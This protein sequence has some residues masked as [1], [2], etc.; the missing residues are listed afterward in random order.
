VTNVCST[1]GLKAAKN[2]TSFT[3]MS[4]TADDLS[5]LEWLLLLYCTISTHQTYTYRLNNTKYAMLVFS[6]RGQNGRTSYSNTV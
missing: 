4:G 3:I 2:K 5:K 6:R 1:I